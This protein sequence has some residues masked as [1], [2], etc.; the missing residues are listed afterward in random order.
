VIAVAR[1]HRTA[2][3][4][5]V[6]A[7]AAALVLVAPPDA[8]AQAAGRIEG[9]LVNGTAGAPPPGGLNVTVHIFKD[10]AKVGERAVAADGSGRFVID[11]LETAAGYLYFPIVEYG[12]ASYFPDRP[13]A[14]DGAP[15]KPVEIR[16]SKDP[17]P[18]ELA[19]VGLQLSGS[20]LT[21]ADDLTVLVARRS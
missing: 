2:F 14:L 12:G 21:P 16:V 8:R 13:V 5:L 17:S 9:Q 6:A 15:S 10:R 19:Q 11:G 20:A 7:L 1:R 18:A 3:G 4:P